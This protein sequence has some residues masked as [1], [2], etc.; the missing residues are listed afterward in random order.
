MENK[1]Y[2]SIF[3]ENLWAITVKNDSNFVLY[4]GDRL[5]DE[6]IK[7]VEFPKDEKLLVRIFDIHSGKLS[8]PIR[9]DMSYHRSFYWY[10]TLVDIKH[11]PII[12]WNCY[13]DSEDEYAKEV[14]DVYNQYRVFLNLTVMEQS[15]KLRKHKHNIFKRN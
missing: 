3:F 7:R 6:K 10:F 2:F 11:I 14:I 8:V 15:G 9:S 1:S 4:Y 12:E 13:T 5:V